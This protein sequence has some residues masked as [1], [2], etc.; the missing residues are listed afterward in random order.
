[1]RFASVELACNYYFAEIGST[2]SRLLTSTVM[3][4]QTANTCHL[5]ADVHDEHYCTGDRNKTDSSGATLNDENTCCKVFFS[6]IQFINTSFQLSVICGTLTGLFATLLWWFELNVR[7]YCNEN[8]DNIPIGNRR[9]RLFLDSFEGIAIMYWPLLTIATICSWSMI[10]KSNV[11]FWCTIAGLVDVTDRLCFYV[12][13]NYGKGRQSYAG[14]VI[15][16]LMSFIVFY[17]FVEHRQI[18]STNRQNKIVITLKIILQIILGLII[19]LPYNYLFLHF[20]RTSP[21]MYRAILSCL[22]IAVLYGPRLIIGNVITSIHG[23]FEPSE[24]FVFAA[25]YLVISIMVTRLTQAEVENLPYFT[26]ISLVHGI[27]NVVDKLFLP[28][29]RKIYKLLCRRSREVMEDNWIYTQQYVVHQSLISMITETSSVIMS[30]AAAYLFRYYYE[31]D[32][33]T[34]KRYDGWDLFTEM[35]IRSSIAVS[36]ELIFNAVALKVQCYLNCPVVDIWKSEWKLIVVINLLQ[37]L[38]AV[39]YFSQYVDTMLLQDILRNSTSD[40]VGLFR[41]L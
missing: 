21:P 14:N 20:Y 41:R 19:Y 16:L 31:K 3:E 24:S 25:P 2:F 23:I 28:V 18:L 32:K 10:K 5:F 27:F 17:K 1:M 6:L 33:S 12:F 7:G 15:F 29:R 38:Y 34:G 40:C 8:W 9:L 11:L 35:C 36:I 39:V 4:Y 13:G 22:L 30:N 37:A 26:I